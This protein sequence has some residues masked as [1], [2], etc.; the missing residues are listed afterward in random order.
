MRA[1][2]VIQGI[3]TGSDLDSEVTELFD[4]LAAGPA[5]ATTDPEK[6]TT[7]SLRRDGHLLKAEGRP[8]ILEVFAGCA[9]LT[10]CLR[11]KGLDT[12]GVDWRGAKLSPETPAVF[13]INL[14]HC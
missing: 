7:W 9:R 10:R 12:W 1:G 6:T 13:M 14:P 8:S 4:D 5:V 11:D 2:R 3:P